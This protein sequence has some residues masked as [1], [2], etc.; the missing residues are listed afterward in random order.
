M[1][2]NKTICFNILNRKKI[3]ER[4]K[5]IKEYSRKMKQQHWFRCGQGYSLIWIHL[6]P[7]NFF[8]HS[9]LI[10]YGYGIQLAESRYKFFWPH[11]AYVFDNEHSSLKSFKLKWHAHVSHL[12]HKSHL[13]KHR[14]KTTVLRFHVIDII[15]YDGIIFYVVTF[16]TSMVIIPSY[17][18]NVL[19]FI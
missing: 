18:Y 3:I 7:L 2:A 5:N 8:F 19:T 9:K 16:V 4:K 17:Q 12:L 1:Q 13:K 10:G 11:L 6:P 14:I 15:L